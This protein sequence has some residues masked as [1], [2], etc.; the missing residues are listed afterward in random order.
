MPLLN[1]CDKVSFWWS[2]FF[3]EKEERK[4]TLPWYFQ[5]SIHTWDK[6]MPQE[7]LIVLLRHPFLFLLSYLMNLISSLFYFHEYMSSASLTLHS[8][9]QL[10]PLKKTTLAHPPWCGIAAPCSLAQSFPT[11]WPHGPAPLSMEYSRQECWSGLPCPPPGDLLNPGIKP[12][13]PTLQAIL[14]LSEPP[15]KPKS[16]RVDSLSLFQGIFPTQE[17]NQGFLHCKQILYQLSYQG[18][19]FDVVI[20]ANKRK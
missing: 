8:T 16:T 7:A 17:S 2:L 1:L 4:K 9:T 6:R 14:L 15:G 13:S 19:P 3:L 12:R 10:F 11:L 5:M 18:S 20:L